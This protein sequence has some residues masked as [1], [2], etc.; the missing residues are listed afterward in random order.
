[1]KDGPLSTELLALELKTKLMPQCYKDLLKDT[2]E[3]DVDKIS[4]YSKILSM[5]DLKYIHMTNAWRLM[6]HLGYIYD[7]NKKYFYTDGS[8]R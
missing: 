2:G 3:K 6:L 1:M 5:L 7:E 8:E 4:S